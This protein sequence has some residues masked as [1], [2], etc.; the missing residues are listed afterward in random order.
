MVVEMVTGE[1]MVSLKV[2]VEVSLTVPPMESVTGRVEVSLMVAAAV[3]VVVT[4]MVKVKAT[5][6]AEF[7]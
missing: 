5:W 4:A 2:P 3:H 6:K 1:A 7:V